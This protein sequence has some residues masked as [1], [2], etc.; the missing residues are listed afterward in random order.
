MSENLAPKLREH[1]DAMGL[2][3]TIVGACAEAK[4]QEITV[5][6]TEKV[7]D[8]FR[9]FIIVS[10]R[11]DRQVQGIANKVLEKLRARGLKPHN[12]EGFDLAHWV[13]MDFGDVV[14]HVFY[15]PL[16]GH[17]DLEGLWAK[18]ERVPFDPA[19]QRRSAELKTA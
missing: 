11:S 6:D 15:E 5:L 14:L 8:L 12:L 10:G 4:A 13:V 1:Q 16:R 9:Y 7:S 19:G 18:A 2:S 3:T 17:Y